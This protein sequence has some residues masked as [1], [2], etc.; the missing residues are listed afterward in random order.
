MNDFRE[1]LSDNLRY[2][3]LG[4]FIL[5]VLVAVFF[6]IRFLSSKMNNATDTKEPVETVTPTPAE[7]PDETPVETPVETP[8]PTPA[9]SDKLE[10]N[11]I[12]QINALVEQY[13]R[14]IAAKDTET[15]KS[16]VDNLSA[17]D[18]AGIAA[19][20]IENYSDL[21]VYTKASDGIGSY[22]VFVTY[23]YKLA[24][25]DTP[26]PGMSQ[27]YIRSDRDSGPYV[28][29]GVPDAK[30]QTFIEETIRSDEVQA[31]MVQ[32]QADYDAALASDPVLNAYFNPDDASAETTAPAETPVPEA[33][34][35]PAPEPTPEPQ[36]IITLKSAANI[37]SGAG[38]DSRVIGS[39]SAGTQMVKLGKDG[40]WFH[41]NVNGVEGYI[42]D[43]FF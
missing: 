26:V 31:V 5:L 36:E 22:A 42:S 6:G 23:R 17:E 38:T 4:V 12:P 11:A 19:D 9:V 14:A 1:W 37:R 3:M 32:V 15:L 21:N 30:T 41:V 16:L 8:T 27:L 40:N 20:T 13:Y 24:G 10:K 33:A 43:M 35:E 39:Y 28:C 7:T 18:E 29:T 2:I 34:P 25:I